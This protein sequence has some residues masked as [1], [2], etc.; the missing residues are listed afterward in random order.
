MAAEK[1]DHTKGDEKLLDH[2]EALTAAQ[3][4]VA[5]RV[6]LEKFG[7][8]ADIDPQVLA[9]LTLVVATNYLAS[10]T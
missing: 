2:A 3:V 10:K 5:E 9:T 1:V 4:G 6:L 7:S 8:I